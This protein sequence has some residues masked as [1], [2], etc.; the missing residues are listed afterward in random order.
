MCLS[1]GQAAGRIFLK[2]SSA[3]SGRGA[4]TA[5]QR[6]GPS[7][8]KRPPTLISAEDF[9]LAGPSYLPDPEHHAYRKDL[10]DVALAGKVIAS[11]YAEPVSRQVGRQAELRAAPSDDAE[12]T[13][14]LEP[15]D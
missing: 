9:A 11:H 7:S 3:T 6:S 2:A 15:G 12:A 14:A 13:C 5:A 8:D 1:S 10:A 4:T